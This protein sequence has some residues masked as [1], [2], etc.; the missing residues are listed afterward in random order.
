[1]RFLLLAGVACCLAAP[2]AHSQAPFSVNDAIQQAVRTHPGVGEAAAN[3][4]ATESELRQVQSTLLP[5]VRLEYRA[6][7]EKFNQALPGTNIAPLGNGQTRWG[8]E[9]TVVVR[10][11]LFDGLTTVSE[12]W[13]QAA[14]VDA[15]A[16]R[17][18]ERTELI[19]LDA[20]EAYIDVVRFTRLIAVAQQNIA[21]HRRILA[22]VKARFEGGRAGEGDL[23]QIVERVE[24]AEAAYFAFRQSLDEARA[25]YRRAVGLEPFN[26]RWPGRLRGLPAS[27]DES[28]AVALTHNPTIRAAQSDADAAKYG[29]HATA[30]AFVPNVALEGRATHGDD[31]NTFI[32]RRDD[33]AGKLVVAWDIFRGGQDSWRRA[34]M[35]E[36]YTEQTMRHAR[37]QRDAFEALDKAWAARTVTTDRIRAL[38]RQIEADRR[39]IVA[40]AKEYDLGQRSL[41]D[42][43]NAENQLFNAQVSLISTQGVAVF[44]D[45]QLLAA[46]GHLIEYLKAPP[47]VDMEP[48]ELGPG[49]LVPYKLPPVLVT[50]PKSGSE[51][52]N[53][54]HPAAGVMAAAVPESPRPVARFSDRWS[55]EARS[56]AAGL[57]GWL[58]SIGASPDLAPA[59]PSGTT[60]PAPG[61]AGTP[62]G[63][64]TAPGEVPAPGQAMSFAP[65]P[66]AP[67]AGGFRA[68]KEVN[69][70]GFTR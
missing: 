7:P 17:V 38:T 48:L 55:N 13:R 58:T 44:A 54:A 20:A 69:R 50:L 70:S 68:G 9:S 57:F 36:R 30:G 65:L 28:L 40:Y 3:R 23:Q 41:V 27:K 64:A 60:P 16:A 12:I 4:R 63:E 35:A 37:L 32:G 39:V 33:V 46:M 21:S 8:H 24:A 11:L 61:L 26:L 1:M 15:A 47:P 2:S 52:L 5:Q 56:P 10:Q 53:I 6:G 19:A 62:A 34:E 49:R 67:Q 18:H 66:L 59:A 25:K 14:R 42:L 22:N 31:Y 43:L 29:F 51:P 45:Y